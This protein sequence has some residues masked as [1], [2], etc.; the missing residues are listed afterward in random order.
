MPKNHITTG[1]VS[2]ASRMAATLSFS[3]TSLFLVLLTALHF[4]KPEIDPSW[5]M[6]S[7]YEIG[8]HGWIMQ[9]AFLCLAF[10]C[11]ALFVAVRSQT[12]TIG[13]RIGLTLLLLG[14]AGMTIAAF[15]VTDPMTTPKDEMTAHGNLHGLGFMPGVP[16]L[17]IAALLISFSLRRD[18]AWA[19]A[20]RML[21]WT[22]Q[23]PWVSLAGL[24][25]TIMVLLP[26]NDGK[27]GPS[28]VVGWP[29][30]LYIVACCVWL[31]AVAW[32]TTKL[33]TES[34]TRTN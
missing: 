11:V 20:R 17:T 1:P 13:G 26:K 10:S 33:R 4:I 24:I 28:V 6:I 16:S 19:S 22:A 12:R 32:R 27:F 5:R 15:N 30:R 23:L 18:A 3:A 31:M 7:E 9:G 25:V 29:N 8:R 14:A 21:L 34:L 2:A